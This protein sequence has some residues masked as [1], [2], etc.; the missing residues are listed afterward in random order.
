VIDP[1]ISSIFAY[2]TV[3]HYVCLSYMKSYPY[4]QGSRFT[5]EKTPRFGGGGRGGLLTMSELG[6]GQLGLLAGRI[7][8][9][10]YAQAGM[11]PDRCP[12]LTDAD[13]KIIFRVVYLW[14]TVALV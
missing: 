7:G 13:V 4:A 3:Y 14:F 5:G 8:V 10:R 2:D 12:G 9:G 1:G 6:S 11:G